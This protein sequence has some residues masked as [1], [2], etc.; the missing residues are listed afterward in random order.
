TLEDTTGQVE[1]VKQGYFPDRSG[2]VMLVYEY[3]V[4]PTSD[5]RTPISKVQG[6]GHG[7][8]YEYD[9]HVPLLW[10]GKGIPKGSSVRKVHPVD[11]APTLG[12]MLKLQGPEEMTG[13]PLSE[14]LE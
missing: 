4:M 6:A 8:G 3:G 10:F 9:T 13:T 14:V 11:I 2:D 1:M 12:R 7:S 5:F